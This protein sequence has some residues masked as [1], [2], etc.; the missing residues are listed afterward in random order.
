MTEPTPA[1]TPAQLRLP[2]I[3]SG[4]I[5]SAR[6]NARKAFSISST[7]MNSPIFLPITI[8]TFEAP[9]F[10]DPTLLMSKPFILDNI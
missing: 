6:L 5:S 7:A 3:A 2:L 4:K 1:R 8:T 9:A 10:P